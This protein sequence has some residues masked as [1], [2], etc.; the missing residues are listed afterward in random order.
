MDISANQTL[1]I[2]KV[3]IGFTTNDI[4]LGILSCAHAASIHFY[5]SDRFIKNDYTRADI[6]SGGL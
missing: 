4:L 5:L 6:L 2:A 3:C 1:N